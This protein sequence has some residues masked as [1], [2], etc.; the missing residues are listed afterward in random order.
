MFLFSFLNPI[1]SLD[2]VGFGFEEKNFRFCFYLYFEI[3]EVWVVRREKR[4]M[5]QERKIEMTGARQ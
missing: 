5:G 2:D 4:R 1:L 3:L